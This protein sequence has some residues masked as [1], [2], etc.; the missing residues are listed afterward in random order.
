MLKRV[1]MRSDIGKLIHTPSDPNQRGRKYMRGSRKRICLASDKITDFCTMPRLRKKLVE[2][3]WK[4][5]IGKKL[6]RSLRD[7]AA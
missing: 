6:V 2:I 3:I 7:L 1:A 5:T 4:P